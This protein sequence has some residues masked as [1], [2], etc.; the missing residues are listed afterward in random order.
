M[1]NYYPRAIEE[2]LIQA[3]T[4]NPAV[5]V[6]GPRQV[7][8]TSLVKAIAA[9]LS[10]P[11]LY[12]D[13]EYPEDQNRLMNPALFLESVQDRTIIID[14]VQRM[15]A[16]FPILRALIDRNRRPGRFILLGSA[17]PDILRDASES[18]AGRVK[19]LELTPFGLHEL[20][21]NTGYQPLWLRGGFP[22]SLF[23]E[24]VEDS[25]DWRE[26]FIRTYTERDLALLGLGAE[27]MLIR[28]LLTMVAHSNGQ[29]LNREN[30]ARS[31][32]ISGVTV[33]KY[34][35]FLEASFIL[36]TV[37]PF[38]TNTKKRLV[39]SPKVYIR[40]T[41]I[42]HS[43]LTIADEFTLMGRT[44]AGA[45]WEGFVLQQ[46][47]ALVQRTDEVWF[48]RTHDGAEADMVITRSGKPELLFEIKLS[49]QP[50]PSRGLYEVM[51]DLKLD[52]AYL[53]TPARQAYRLSE[54]IT[55]IGPGDLSDVLV[56]KA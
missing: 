49:D 10:F 5:V 2:R 30:F 38:F 8:K 48:Y 3:V 6:M 7:G 45:S 37:Q 27:P 39:K 55:V 26:S 14:E 42:L 17:S 47:W 25:F 18:L 44:E 31:L 36:K 56:H 24:T 46:V 16:L 9:R 22:E 4:K 35:D 33:G 53:V 11:T 32:G 28:R 21:T 52:R 50:T 43:L 1:S 34:L 13:L 19:Y 20:H 23:A 51:E 12:L 29:V 41:G 15:P 40:D 54:K